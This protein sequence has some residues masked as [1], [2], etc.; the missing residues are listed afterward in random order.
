MDN[1]APVAAENVVVTQPSASHNNNSTD[2][3]RKVS[4]V[5]A[6]EKSTYA[7][8]NPSYDTTA[9]YKR[10]ISQVGRNSVNCKLFAI[11]SWNSMSYESSSGDRKY[12]GLKYSPVLNR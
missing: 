10:K 6:P 1:P 7:Y 4:I 11:I 8:D 2:V 12:S 9:N 5:E 3:K